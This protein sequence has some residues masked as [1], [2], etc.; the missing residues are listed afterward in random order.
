MSA[1]EGKPPSKIVEFP[2]PKPEAPEAPEERAR[3]LKV[4]V[5]RLAR[6]S[7]AEWMFW[8]D[9]SAKKHGIEPAK[10][11]AM[12]EA[13][14]RVIEKKAREDKAKDRQREQREERERERDAAR[15]RKDKER[16]F[17]D[18]ARLPSEACE[19][20]LADLAK[21]PDEDIDT[22]RTEF[23]TFVGADRIDSADARAEAWQKCE[24]LARKP[25]ILDEFAA[26]LTP[27][28]LVGERRAAK[29]LYLSLTSR[30]FTRP[31]SVGV[32]GVSSAGKSYAVETALRFF[33]PEAY[34]V[35]T[36]MSE[37]TLV[38][39]PESFVHRVLILYETAGLDS[40]FAAYLMRS[41]LSE[42]RLRYETVVSGTT[43]VIEREGPT[44][45]IS[46]STSLHLDPETETRMLGVTVSDTQEQTKG[47]LRQL[48]AQDDD[49]GGD[50]KIDF[51][52]WRALQ[53]WLTTGPV[54]V[55]I[56]FANQLA[57]LVPPVAVRLR[58]DF[59]TVLTLIRTHALLHQE[60][61]QKDAAGRIVA[62]VEDY[63]AVRDLVADLVAEEIDARVRAET[64]EVVALVRK[65]LTKGRQ[66]VRQ[67]DLM[68]HLQ[69]DKS[70]LSRR[71]AAAL[72]A[73]FLQNREKSKYRP[74]RLVLGDPLPKEVQ[75]LP[76]P[77][78][79]RT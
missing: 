76:S 60:T 69:L 49:D 57:D 73:G 59:K 30:L 23:E 28:G 39:S 19:A 42:G 78:R 53:V 14:V 72:D 27:A 63:A 13:T 50:G 15:K 58:R 18:L 24:T 64:R 20:G 2:G 10:L 36:G 9:D 12:V 43:H 47:V 54:G 67:V 46:T 17:K 1:T 77:K 66:E 25:K 61:R 35:L 45:L 48:A 5:E 74:A 31:V 68:P 79:L 62:T 40:G 16:A 70:S 6:Q 44:G 4:E 3:R 7:P 29:L 21:R 37:R 11:K 56:P 32:R 26:D 34:Y 41:L 55:V 71:V 33:P 75:I 52:R 8:L 51:D 22:I 65:L 38:Y